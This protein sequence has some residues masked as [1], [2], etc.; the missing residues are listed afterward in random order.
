MPSS[1][2]RSVVLAVPAMLTIMALPA[3]SA[4]VVTPAASAGR[5]TLQVIMSLTDA[6]PVRPG[7]AAVTRLARAS[8][9]QLRFVRE[10]QP[11]LYVY[12]LSANGGD[13][14]CT[15]GLERLRRDVRVRSIDIDTRRR[16][17]PADVSR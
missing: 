8:Q 3:A 11:H 1:R 7:A 12:R 14:D 5:C 13:V 17:H 6:D 4:P 16:I 2:Y 10:I 15:R 9:V